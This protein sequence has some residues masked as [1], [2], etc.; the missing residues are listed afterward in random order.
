MARTLREQYIQ[1]DARGRIQLP[2]ELRGFRLF[3]LGE[4]DGGY[5]LVP[6]RFEEENLKPKQSNLWLSQEVDQ[7]LKKEMFRSL[8][9]FFEKDRP[10]G[11]SAVFLYGS[12]ARGDALSN[13][14]FDLG[15]LFDQ[16]P[17]LDQRHALCDRLQLLLRDEFSVLKS[18]GVNSEPSFHFFSSNFQQ[19]DLPPIYYSIAT[20]GIKIWQVSRGWDQFHERIRKIMKHRKL[21]SEGQGKS[22]KW[23][24]ETK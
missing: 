20:D 11:L 5:E 2:K 10:D 17:S 6:L 7:Y 15:L 16:Y 23:V 24:W 1:P 19:D 4:K 8:A 12:R 9:D 22:R 14:D 18:H 3:K 13:S 21:R